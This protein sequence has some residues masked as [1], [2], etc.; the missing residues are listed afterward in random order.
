MERV[1]GIAVKRKT[2]PS[3]GVTTSGTT[4]TSMDTRLALN[5]FPASDTL[6]ADTRLCQSSQQSVNHA[7]DHTINHAVNQSCVR[8]Q[9]DEN[10][11]CLVCVC[12]CLVCV[13]VWCVCVCVCVCARACV[14]ACVC[15]CVCTR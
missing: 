5:H 13:C 1:S 6:T 3:I 11:V 8:G 2:E 4:R 10:I 12:V 14:R 9:R 7:V 15:V